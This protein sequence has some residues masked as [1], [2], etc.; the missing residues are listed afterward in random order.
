MQDSE[1]FEGYSDNGLDF[2]G[3]ELL[4]AGTYFYI[5]EIDGKKGIDGYFYI[6][7]E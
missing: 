7:R 3:K 1:R 4:P 5:I 6:V 2:E